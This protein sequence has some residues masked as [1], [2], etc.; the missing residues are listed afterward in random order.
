M[1]MDVRHNFK[2]APPTLASV[3]RCVLQNTS[4]LV[5][6]TVE[7]TVRGIFTVS[8]SL[9]GFYEEVI[10]DM[11]SAATDFEKPGEGGERMKK[12]GTILRKR[13]YDIKTLLE[14]REKC[15]GTCHLSKFS[16]DAINGRCSNSLKFFQTYLKQHLVY[17][18]S[19]RM[20]RDPRFSSFLACI[21]LLATIVA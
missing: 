7:K 3:G 8:R 18:K 5:N 16:R 11:Q 1:T 10:E 19:S 9:H 12:P 17:F 4:N 2:D 13:V 20:S 14:L 6:Q 21:T 15:T